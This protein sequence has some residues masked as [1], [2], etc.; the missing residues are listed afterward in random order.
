M[1]F[2]VG[3]DYCSIIVEVCKY[4]LMSNNNKKNSTGSVLGKIAIGLAGIV[5][6]LLI[7][8]AID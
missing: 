6:G 1:G 3:L 8:K 2:G 7:G 5:G 4:L